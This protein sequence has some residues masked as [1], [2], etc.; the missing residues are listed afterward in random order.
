MKTETLHK[1]LAMVGFGAVTAGAAALGA[2]SKPDAW[3][4]SL[5]KPWFQPPNWVFAPVWTGLYSL[6][7]VS[8]YRVWASPPSKERNEALA[9]W[10]AQMGLNAVW[11]PLFF[12]AHNPRAALVD[13]SALNIAISNYQ[14]A[15]AKVD[16]EAQWMMA[17]YKAWV[18]FATLL[19]GS[20]VRNNPA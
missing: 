11:T 4:K 7:A 6:I 1:A 14:T 15:A 2:M 10:G 13:I 18:R 20:I 12:G 19:N 17:P 16:P 9:W 3:F 8:G 5:K